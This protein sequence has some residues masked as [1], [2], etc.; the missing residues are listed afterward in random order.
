M[1]MIKEELQMNY[2]DYIASLR[3]Q[4]AKELLQ[5]E[6]LSIQ[7]IAEQVGYNDYFYFTKVFKK[8]QGISPSKYRKSL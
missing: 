6:V 8:V 5:N 1:S 7:E 4:R 3:I 2:S